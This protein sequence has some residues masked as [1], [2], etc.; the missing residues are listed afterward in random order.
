[1]ETCKRGVILQH[2]CLVTLRLDPRRRDITMDNFHWK[3]LFLNS[4]K[5]PSLLGDCEWIKGFIRISCVI[6]LKV[7]IIIFRCR[8]WCQQLRCDWQKW[9]AC[10]TSSHF[11]QLIAIL[12][13][14][15]LLFERLQLVLIKSWPITAWERLNTDEMPPGWTGNAKQ[16]SR[17]SAHWNFLKFWALLAPQPLL[18]VYSPGHLFCH[19]LGSLSHIILAVLS[20]YYTN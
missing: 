15:S 2:R 4:N 18:R 9:Y 1:M 7:I 19:S 13:P 12:L 17:Q 10:L 16:L 8:S 6:C 5:F 3:I 11:L 14:S 20:G